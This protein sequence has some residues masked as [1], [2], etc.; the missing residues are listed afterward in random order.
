MLRRTNA[1]EVN[2]EFQVWKQHGRFPSI[3][4]RARS[5][6]HPMA[7]FA[8]LVTAAFLSMALM[9]PAG[10]IFAPRDHE[11]RVQESGKSYRLPPVDAGRA[12]RGQ[13][14]GAE[15]E[16]CVLA[17]IRESGKNDTHRVRMIASAEPIHTT[18]NVF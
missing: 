10:A 14:W 15:T 16:T 12:C 2:R 5:N 7:M 18:P 11:A 3:A 4:L 1:P 8:M 9:A 6:D 13:A 17:I